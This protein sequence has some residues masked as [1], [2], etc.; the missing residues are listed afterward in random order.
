MSSSSSLAAGPL[1]PTAASTVTL[2]GVKRH[3]GRNWTQHEEC[4]ALAAEAEFIK[5]KTAR[6]RDLNILFD[7]TGTYPYLQSVGFAACM[8]E[9]KARSQAA[10]KLARDTD[11]LVLELVRRWS[12]RPGSSRRV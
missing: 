6:D 1:H 4:I 10:G 8:A 12:R 2:S 5:P 11:K 9:H 7:H 3:R